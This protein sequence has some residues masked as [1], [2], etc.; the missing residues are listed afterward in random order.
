MS[1][2]IDKIKERAKGDIKRIVLP[3]SSDKRVLEA[4]SITEKEGFAHPI[5]IGD[6]NEISHIANINNIDISSVEIINPITF[7]DTDKLIKEFYE[8]RKNKGVSLEEATRIIKINTIGNSKCLV[9][10]IT[11]SFFVLFLL[12]QLLIV[13][14]GYK[15]VIVITI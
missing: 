13:I 2:I 4:A 12:F 11:Y 10:S 14:I 15:A 8:I 9:I 7:K 6:D 1:T 3:E 5:L